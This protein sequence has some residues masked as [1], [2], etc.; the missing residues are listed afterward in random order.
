MLRYW[1]LSDR[2]Q[3]MT[4]NLILLSVTLINR[5]HVMAHTV[6]T[7]QWV[8]IN[9]EVTPCLPLQ[10]HSP[11]APAHSAPPRLPCHTRVFLCPFLCPFLCLAV[12]MAIHLSSFKFHLLLHNVLSMTLKLLQILQQTC[13]F[14]NKF[15]PQN[16]GL[17]PR[18]LTWDLERRR[19]GKMWFGQPSVII[20]SNQFH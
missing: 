8:S 15:H 6:A 20:E 16:F 2:Q 14:F 5:H 12:G 17:E 19:W 13:Y 9:H 3:W 10:L 4:V 18:H 11:P 7:S 1:T